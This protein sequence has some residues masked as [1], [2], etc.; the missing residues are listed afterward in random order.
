[1]VGVSTRTYHGGGHLHVEQGQLVCR[2]GPLG[3]RVV[4]LA[5]IRHA[6]RD[7]QVYSARLIPPW[8]SVAALIHDGTRTVRA[9][10]PRPRRR[11]LV[12]ALT[13]A[14]FAVGLESTWFSRGKLP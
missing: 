12:S 2:V 9:S 5:E 13:E 11:R 10:V 6:G 3:R 8:F 7:V 4:G 14:G 1:V